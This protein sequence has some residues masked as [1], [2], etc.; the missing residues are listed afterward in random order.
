MEW[1]LT[2]LIYRDH[3]LLKHPQTHL[4]GQVQGVFVMMTNGFGAY[5]GTIV[6]SWAINEF[7]ILSNGSTDWKGAWSAFAVYADNSGTFYFII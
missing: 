3:Y 6:S 1:L 2:F 5:L 4:F 7:F